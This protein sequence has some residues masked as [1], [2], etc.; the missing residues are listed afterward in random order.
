MV[1]WDEVMIE[2]V[3]VTATSGLRL[4]DSPRDGITL[5]VLPNKA[6]LTLLGRETWLRVSS[7][8]KVGFVLADY[9]EPLHDVRPAPVP[10]P[11]DPPVDPQIPQYSGAVDIIEYNPQGDVFRGAPLRIDAEFRPCIEYLG[12]LALHHGIKIFVTSS[13]REPLKPVANAI[14]KP[15]Q[16]SNHHVG[17]GIDMNL[18]DGD[19]HIRSDELGDLERLRQV[20]PGA[21]SFLMEV[22]R[23]KHYLRWGGD[24]TDKDPVHIDNGLNVF[25]EQAYATKLHSLW[26]LVR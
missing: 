13:L 1:Q 22:S 20:S 4:R 10:V 9:V 7:N 26:G 19:R 15:A 25:H 23:L 12:G 6:E 5:D 24:F 21:H 17:H 14:V 3:R 16:Y 11:P 8:G 2:R 18:V